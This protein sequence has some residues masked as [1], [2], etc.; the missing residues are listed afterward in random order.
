MRIILA[1]LIASSAFVISTPA[2]E[3]Q[4][5]ICRQLVEMARGGGDSRDIQRELREAIKAA[6]SRRCF[7]FFFG[8][9]DS[10]C[11]ALKIAPEPHAGEKRAFV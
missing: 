10:S 8:K 4:S 11:R 5:R 9:R 2:A 6:D 7:G 3:A 1:L